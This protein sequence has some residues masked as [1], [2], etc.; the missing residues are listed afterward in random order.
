MIIQQ[1]SAHI[2]SIILFPASLNNIWR[3]QH[4]I[5]PLSDLSVL[6]RR[7]VGWTFSSAFIEVEKRLLSQWPG[8]F[9][10]KISVL[11]QEAERADDRRLLCLSL[12]DG[13]KADDADNEQD[14]IADAAG[15][16]NKK[17]PEKH[18]ADDAEQDVNDRKLERLTDMEACIRRALAAE[19]GD[20]NACRA[21]KIAQHG[22]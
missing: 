8:A 3:I 7:T 6:H 10:C 17:G 11:S 12:A 18:R 21:E 20:D 15:Y 16:R 4:I 1:M 9:S 19:Q 5:Q 14:G 22:R 13:E 2:Q